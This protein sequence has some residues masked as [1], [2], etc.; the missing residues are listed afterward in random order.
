VRFH[1]QPFTVYTPV[2]MSCLGHAIHP[3]V[4]AG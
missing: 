2:S 1:S 3:A 4:L